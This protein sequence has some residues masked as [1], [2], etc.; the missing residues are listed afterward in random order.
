MLRLCSAVL[1]FKRPDPATCFSGRREGG[2]SEEQ[3]LCR[4]EEIH[5]PD[6]TQKVSRKGGRVNLAKCAS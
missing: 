1:W 3:I 5:L 4:I 6:S 2:E